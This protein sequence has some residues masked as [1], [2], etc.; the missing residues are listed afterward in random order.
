MQ[1][2]EFIVRIGAAETVGLFSENVS[3]FVDVGDKIVPVLIN[4]MKELENIESPLQ[5]SFEAL[6]QLTSNMEPEEI[7]KNF[8]ELLTTLIVF[9]D[10]PSNLVKQLSLETMS[11]VILAADSKMREIFEQLMPKLI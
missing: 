10:H 6:S 5:K 11:N 2:P 9:L 8:E 4:V 3:E 1:D 7:M